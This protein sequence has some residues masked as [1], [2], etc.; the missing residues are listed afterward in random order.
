M[1]IDLDFADLVEK[2]LSPVAQQLNM[3][4]S[5]VRKVA[6]R[7]TRKDFKACKEEFGTRMSLIQNEKR[8]EIRGISET[9]SI[10]SANIVRGHL[11]FKK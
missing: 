7:M 10:P 1:E 3:H 8:I 5:K 2:R 9:I 4:P 11:V 6:D